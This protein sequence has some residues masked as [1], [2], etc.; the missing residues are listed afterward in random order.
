MKKVKDDEYV[1]CCTI[2]NCSHINTFKESSFKG[3]L[4]LTHIKFIDGTKKVDNFWDNVP[5]AF[6]KCSAFI[7]MKKHYN[8][9]HMITT[10]G[11]L[12]PLFRHGTALLNE[13]KRKLEEE[14]CQK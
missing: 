8:K 9:H 4:K 13:R 5:G 10:Q 3:Q 6:K 1:I 7:R 12:P 11:G 2:W 14:G